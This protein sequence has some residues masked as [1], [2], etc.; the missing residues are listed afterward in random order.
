MYASNRTLLQQQRSIIFE[1]EWKKKTHTELQVLSAFRILHACYEGEGNAN[2]NEQIKRI[3]K[4][5]L[6]R[7]PC[8]GS[9]K[10]GHS[11]DIVT[12]PEQ[13]QPQVYDKEWKE[14]K[15]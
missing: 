15:V 5:M 11:K 2:Y 9:S 3:E 14:Q 10:N 4:K 13:I 12:I 7:A 8:D 1:N 6:E